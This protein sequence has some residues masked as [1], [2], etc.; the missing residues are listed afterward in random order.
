MDFA[1]ELEEYVSKRQKTTE[2]CQEIEPQEST[3]QV[4]SRICRYGTNCKTLNCKFMHK[5]YTCYRCG[6][7]DHYIQQCPQNICH[8]CGEKGHIAPNCIAK[9]SYQRQQSYIPADADKRR[10]H[11]EFDD[12]HRRYLSH[13]T[14]SRYETHP[15]Q[16]DRR[17][18]NRQ[19]TMESRQPHKNDRR[20]A[21]ESSYARRRE[22][23][24]LWRGYDDSDRSCTRYGR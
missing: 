20:R 23:S 2:V 6:G 24:F 5:T 14:E 21:M 13:H 16:D 17:G 15:Y 22:D 1:Q 7:K 12:Y 8:L 19:Y 18:K 3:I 10:R 4:S 11:E 9:K